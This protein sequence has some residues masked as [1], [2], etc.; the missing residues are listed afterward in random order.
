[1]SHT[2]HTRT[3]RGGIIHPLHA[4]SGHAASHAFTSIQKLP[5]LIM[6]VLNLLPCRPRP[7]PWDCNLRH[8]CININT[9]D[10]ITD[11]DYCSAGSICWWYV[12]HGTC[13]A[14]VSANKHI[15]R[16]CDDNLIMVK[17]GT[18]SEHKVSIMFWS[19]LITPTIESGTLGARHS[20]V[21]CISAQ[22]LLDPAGVRISL[23]CDAP[24]HL[25]F[26]VSNKMFNWYGPL[27]QPR[28]DN[29]V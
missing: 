17:I 8:P 9:R 20:L 18:T 6:I 11:W 21:A 10:V 22:I 14:T 19:M 3:N 23:Q 26:V 5:H 2:P 25:D 27:I 24:Q 28:L 15:I 29:S 16:S 13:Y 7:G 1:M 4:P 12:Y